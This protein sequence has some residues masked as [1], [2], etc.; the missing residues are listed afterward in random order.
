MVYGLILFFIVIVFLEV[1]GLIS[2]KLWRELTA[3][4][5]FLTI[6]FILS[7]LLVIGVK[8]PSPNDGIIFL[9]ETVSNQFK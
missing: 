6:G 3:F 2:K 9:I 5:V 1:P 8:I 7:F 4:S